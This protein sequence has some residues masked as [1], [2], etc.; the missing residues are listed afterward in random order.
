MERSLVHKVVCNFQH[1]K[2]NTDSQYFHS[3][4]VIS[5]KEKCRDGAVHRRD[6]DPFSLESHVNHS[7]IGHFVFPAS[8][9]FKTLPRNHSATA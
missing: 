1:R 3:G 5:V 2:S 7:S 6:A 9:L 8:T 4:F